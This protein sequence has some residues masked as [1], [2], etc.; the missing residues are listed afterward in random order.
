MGAVISVLK[1]CSYV[2]DHLIQRVARRVVASECS[3]LGCNYILLCA[4]LSIE[5][6][7]FQTKHCYFIVV[8]RLPSSEMIEQ[9]TVN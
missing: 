4:G 1:I 5:Q 3:P 6:L 9:L 2:P 8:C 7:C